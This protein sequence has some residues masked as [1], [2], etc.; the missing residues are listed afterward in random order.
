MTMGF[1]LGDI[2]VFRGLGQGKIWYALPVMVV[3][4]APDPVALFWRA[5]TPGKFRGLSPGAKV[6]PPEV[7]SDQMLLFDKIWTETDVLMLI[8]PGAAHAVYVMWEEGQKGLRCWYINLQQPLARTAT[9]FD[10]EDYWLDIVVSPDR[11]EWRWKDEDQLKEAVAMGMYSPAK[12]CEIR[13][14]G[15]RVIGLL[16]ANQPPFCD[17]WENWQAPGDWNIPSLPEGWDCL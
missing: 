15:E 9:G 2:I 7:R 16:Q 10:T 4:D 17:G 11:S 13:A 1:D 3:K 12:A 14:E 6:T 5:G 8:V